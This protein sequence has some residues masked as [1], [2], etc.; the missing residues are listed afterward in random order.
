MRSLR[1]RPNLQNYL[2]SFRSDMFLSLSLLITLATAISKSSCVTC[3]RRSRSAYMP[4]SVHTALIS[5]PEAP[6]SFS[7]IF[8]KSIP[9]IKF[10]LREWIL[11]MSARAASF[12]F[13]NSIF[14]SI[15]PG[16]MS[17]SSRMSRR[18][19]AMSTLMLDADS[20]PSSWLSNSSIVRWISRSPPDVESYLLVPTASISSMKTMD[21]A[22]SSARRNISLTS[23][24][25]SPRYFWIS[26]D[27]TIRKKVADVWFATALASNVLPV[28]GGPYRITP[29][30]GLMPISS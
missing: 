10:I 23:F 8:A 4:D 24:G 13:G 15:R 6:G 12:G 9:L 1:Q 2:N 22:C 29:L 26:S 21:G 17:A 11:R 3:T 16:R 25:P 18:F 20:N 5:A 27:P 28:P 30:G 7:A 14:L 19:V